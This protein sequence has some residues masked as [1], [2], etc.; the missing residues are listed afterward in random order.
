MIE[1]D[2]L[3]I[4]FDGWRLLENASCVFE[5]GR[6]YA[7][8]GRNGSGKST[9]LRVMAGLNDKYQGSVLVEGNNLRRLTPKLLSRSIAYVATRRLNGGAML[10]GEAVALGR[11][12]YTNWIGTMSAADTRSVRRAFALVG[13]SGWEN[14]RLDTLSDGEYQ[15]VMLARAL[16]Q[17]TSAILLDEPTSFLDVVARKQIVELLAH[18][19]ASENK[20]VIY[21]THEIVLAQQEADTILVLN[22]PELIS[23][24]PTD[25]QRLSE[26]FR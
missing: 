2:N 6:L 4:G 25:T 14:R 12:P 20:T 5:R 11:A 18:I 16:A 21:S 17:D 8:T 19:A 1:L 24:S 23:L 13:M 22:P 26:L 10:C 3:T 9:L 15:R 7:L